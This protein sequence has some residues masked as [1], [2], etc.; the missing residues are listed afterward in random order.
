MKQKAIEKL[1]KLAYTDAMTGVKNRNAFEE[2]REQMNKNGT[3]LE[4][5]CAI[6]VLF[7]DY[8]M[9]SRVFG[10]STCDDAI[11]SIARCITDVLGEKADI[12]R[13]AENEFLCFSRKGL[14]PNFIK[15]C[16][17]LSEIKEEK[18]Y[19]FSPTVSFTRFDK[20]NHKTFDDFVIYCDE[21]ATH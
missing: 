9:I 12:Y 4:R 5:M 2:M 11:R 13:T 15:V 19:P 14:Y 18:V 7:E 20:K 16:E 1:F 3:N 17:A 8:D 10:N 6:S 21:Y